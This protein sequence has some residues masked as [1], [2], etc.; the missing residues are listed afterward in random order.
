ML[1]IDDE[2]NGEIVKFFK[3]IAATINELSRKRDRED[4]AARAGQTVHKMCRH[5]WTNVNN[6]T[7]SLRREGSPKQKRSA[8]CA[9]VMTGLYNNKTDC[10][11]CGQYIVK[12]KHGHDLS[13]N[14]VKTSSFP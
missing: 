5:T 1:L 10:L 12:E 14:E 6:I 2:N 9:S 11:F 4:V 13:A 8:P 3:K 7:K